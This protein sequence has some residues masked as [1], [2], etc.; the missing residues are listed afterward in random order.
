[1][2]LQE[3]DSMEQT[4]TKSLRPCGRNSNEWNGE[5]FLEMGVDFSRKKN[6]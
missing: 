2:G 1:M 4:R 3:I 5:S 6:N